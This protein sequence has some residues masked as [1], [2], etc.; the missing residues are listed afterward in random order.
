MKLIKEIIPPS[1]S[2][3]IRL[4]SYIQHDQRRGLSFWS[5]LPDERQRYYHSVTNISFR[6]GF[7]YKYKQ[8][9]FEK[10]KMGKYNKQKVIA[11]QILSRKYKK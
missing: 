11:W 4:M 7:I 6:Y 10:K 8:G 1:A 5:E 3:N 9:R 2:T